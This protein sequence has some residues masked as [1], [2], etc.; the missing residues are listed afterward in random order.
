[1]DWIVL[2]PFSS[3][4]GQTFPRYDQSFCQGGELKRRKYCLGRI[5]SRALGSIHVA[6]YY[7][8][9]NLTVDGLFPTWEGDTQVGG[10]KVVPPGEVVSGDTDFILKGG[11][12]NSSRPPE[13]LACGIGWPDN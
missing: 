3:T 1:M 8:S 12:P 2:S 9:D 6:L 5:C 13:H 7:N 4:E 10:V 11:N